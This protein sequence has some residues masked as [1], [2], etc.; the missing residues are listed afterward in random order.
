MDSEITKLMS[1]PKTKAAPKPVE[2]QGYIGFVYGGTMKVGWTR[3][4]VV[5][6]GVSVDDKFETFKEHYGPAVRGRHIKTVAP[7]TKLQQLMEELKDYRRGNHQLY[8]ISIPTATNAMKKVTGSKKASLLGPVAETE[9]ENNL[10]T[11]AVDNDANNATNDVAANEA[12]NDNTDAG[13]ANNEEADGED[14]NNVDEEGDGDEQDAEE[15]VV[16]EVQPVVVAKP[17]GKPAGKQQATVQPPPPSVQVTATVAKPTK[18][19][20]KQAVAKPVAQTPA[21]V[22][23]QVQ[24]PAPAKQAVA[25]KKV[26]ARKK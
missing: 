17:T 21:P 1:K 19:P 14:G 5:D 18:P 25:A 9:V 11:D 7:E 23:V 20:A 4:F 26:V 15:E 6:N 16:P 12:T 2:K 22:Q 3:L 8:E 13:D 10:T 24:P